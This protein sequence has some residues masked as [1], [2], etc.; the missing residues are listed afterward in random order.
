VS[1]APVRIFSAE[2]RRLLDRDDAVCDAL[3][4][5]FREHSLR[6][7]AE[8]DIWVAARLQIEPILRLADH[9]TAARAELEAVERRLKQ[10]A[11]DDCPN[12]PCGL[13]RLLV[14]RQK[15]FKARYD[16]AFFELSRGGKR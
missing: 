14:L 10:H 1:A 3:R 11:H 5:V 13:Y 8:A 7:Q 4:T 12:D 2:D 9:A 16:R 15:R 6:P